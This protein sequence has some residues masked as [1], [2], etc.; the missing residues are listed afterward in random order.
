MS[1][2]LSY[3]QYSKEVFERTSRDGGLEINWDRESE[4]VG[5]YVCVC[6]CELENM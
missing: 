5:V 3:I 2:F 1:K 6:V 4:R